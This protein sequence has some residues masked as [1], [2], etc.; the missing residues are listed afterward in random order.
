MSDK[1]KKFIKKIK[2]EKRFILFMQISLTIIFLLTWELLSKY[3][4]INSFIASSPSRI[5]KTLS[6]LY[7][8]GTL[9]YHIWI[10]AISYKRMINQ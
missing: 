7:L 10:T 3:N 4:I 6:N 1:Q 8:D 9:F 5:L 2:Q